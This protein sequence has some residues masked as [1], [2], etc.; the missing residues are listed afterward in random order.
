MSTADGCFVLVSWGSYLA[1]LSR[2][3]NL[4]LHRCQ[5]HILQTELET[6][7]H[8]M[9]PPGLPWS[10]CQAWHSDRHLGHV[11]QLKALH[12]LDQH[13]SAPEGWTIFCSVSC[14][15]LACWR[16][17][18]AAFLS[19]RSR[20][21]F[22]STRP[23]LEMPMIG[24]LQKGQPLTASK[25]GSSSLR[26]A[27]S[28]GHQQTCLQASW[29]KEQLAANDRG[30]GLLATVTPGSCQAG[31]QLPAYQVLAAAWSQG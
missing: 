21:R 10:P 17:V 4:Q 25:C 31:M 14:S 5:Q 11:S 16:L 27:A 9:A 20:A 6:A 22:F 30:L 23:Y 15:C 1:M 3:T 18:V 13:S 24:C 7:G 19:V 12:W 8:D 29:S 2:S 28:P 26:E